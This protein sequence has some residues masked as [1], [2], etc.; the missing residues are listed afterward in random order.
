MSEIDNIVIEYDNEITN[1]D[2]EYITDITDIVLSVGAD[3][4]SVFSINGLT[5]NVILTYSE[6]LGSGTVSQGVY[7]YNVSHSL[8]AS[9][10]IVSLYNT[11]N[12]LVFSEI[13]IV[14][15]NNVTIKSL[16]DLSGYKVVVQK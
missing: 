2:I 7:S 6:T 10:V 3:V 5:G 14:D 11:S 4:Q 1:I 15:N 8:N 12:R 16:I 9:D 13:E